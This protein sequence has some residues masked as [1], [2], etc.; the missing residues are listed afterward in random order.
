M[1]LSTTLYLTAKGADEIAHRT[2]RLG[3]RARCVLL[4]LAHPQSIEFVLQKS[5]FPD[6][7]IIEAIDTLAQTGFIALTPEV[8]CASAPG[9]ASLRSGAAPVAAKSDSVTPGSDDAALDEEIN[10]PEA[11]FLLIDFC[12]DCFGMQAEALSEAIRNSKSV[13]ALR[14]E[15]SEL[16]GMIN[17]QKPEQQEALRDIIRAINAT[18]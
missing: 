16:Q 17:A 11:R 10:L 15:L 13:G 2:M 14:V 4:L 1:D 3:I 8:A 5:V 7:E 6:A 18:A 12:V 9:D